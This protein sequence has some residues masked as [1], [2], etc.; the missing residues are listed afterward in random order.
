[1]KN[2]TNDDKPLEDISLENE[3]KKCTMCKET[4]KLEALKCRFCNHLF[5]ED[6]VNKEI[7]KRRDEYQAES[8]RRRDA[9]QA[10]LNNKGKCPKCF[11]KLI[12]AYIED[13]GQ[14]EW[15]TNCEASLKVIMGKDYIEQNT[16]L[17]STKPRPIPTGKAKSGYAWSLAFV[18]LMGILLQGLGGLAIWLVIGLNV[19]FCI[20]DESQLKKSGFGA[21]NVW[22][23]FLVPV[24][25]YQ[26][27]NFVGDNLAYF[28]VW[29]GCFILSV[30]PIWKF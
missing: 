20:L 9:Y 26:R 14:G 23:L 27:A 4:I 5:N 2:I 18:P 15:C 12:R 16:S 11:T 7:D 25:L 8:N 28:F 17:K 10:E 24:Y 21:P 30:L 13:G 6:D 29:I 1:M 3:T 19:L 22:W